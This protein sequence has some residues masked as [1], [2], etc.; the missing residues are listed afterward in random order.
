[1]SRIGSPPVRCALSS[2]ALLFA[3]FLSG[4]AAE[5]KRLDATHTVVLDQTPEETRL[6]V[7]SNE[8][9]QELL[10]LDAFPAKEV[11]ASPR[12]EVIAP[13]SAYLHFYSDYGIYNGSI[14]YIFDLSSTKPPVKIRYDILALTSVSRDSGKLS[15]S[16]SF[17]HERHA[18]IIV[19]PRKSELPSYQIVDGAHS[20][21]QV[22]DEP[23][24]LRGPG[25]EA[26]LVEN[27][28]PP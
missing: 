20:S 26:V 25:G 21:G 7:I 15:Y 19:G 3:L 4:A 17:G 11:A 9:N 12:L 16:A 1:M 22:S 6:F 14:K 13:N 18:S 27:T 23:A 24:V 5:S 8:T 10:Q 28:T 2:G